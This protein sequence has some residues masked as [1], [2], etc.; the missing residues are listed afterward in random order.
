MKYILL[1][2]LLL[3]ADSLFAQAKATTSI[4]KTEELYLNST[5]DSGKL[6]KR[7]FAGSVGEVITSGNFNYTIKE[8]N[9]QTSY[10]VTYIYLDGS[11]LSMKIIDSI[12]QLIINKHK[13]GVTFIQ[14]ARQY[15]MDGNPN[16]GDTDYFLEGSMEPLFEHAIRSHK[17]GEV[18]TV[19]IPSNSWYYVVKKTHPEKTKI[20][21]K[22][23]KAR[24]SS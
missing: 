5:V 4:D 13:A 12:R 16:F 3:L 2:P 20:S 21:L 17:T 6:D 1:F 10:R 11:K 8:K 23:V 9:I 22:V 15:N 7:L 19:D 24:K 14:L 18:F